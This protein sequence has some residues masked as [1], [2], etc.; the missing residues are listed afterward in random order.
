M[1]ATPSP[2]CGCPAKARLLVVCSAQLVS[3]RLAA[4]GLPVVLDVALEGARRGE[5]AQLVPHHGLGDEHRDVLAT[6]VHGDRVP[7]HVRDDRGPSGPGLDDRLLVGLVQHVH[8]LEQVVVDEGA[9]L[10]AAWHPSLPP[11]SALLTGATTPDDELVAW[12]VT[13]GAALRDR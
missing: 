3:Q 13:T 12:L 9:L 10:Q 1:S 4:A 8:L 6:V 2:G 11:C 7:Q 5:L